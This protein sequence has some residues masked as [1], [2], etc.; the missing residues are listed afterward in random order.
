[1]SGQNFG[2]GVAAC[3]AA[4]ILLGACS[5]D[6]P[7]DSPDRAKPT[8]SPAACRDVTGEAVATNGQISAGPFSEDVLK[9]RRPS[10]GSYKVWV[11]TRTVGPQEVT[12][13]LRPP[14]S[15]AEKAYQRRSE[16]VS[17]PDFAQFFPG[18]VEITAGGRWQFRILHGANEFCFHVEFPSG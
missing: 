11:G 17:H 13:L 10:T 2:G 18:L 6:A 3:L 7:A 15:Q 9:I 14:D 1:M 12:L 16:G 5:P 8:P 4:S